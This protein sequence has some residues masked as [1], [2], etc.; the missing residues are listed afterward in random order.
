MTSFQ[1]HTPSTLFTTEHAC[2]TYL[3]QKRWPWGFKCPFCRRVQKDMAPAYTVV[4]R[5]CR[6]Q[7]SITAHTLMHGSKKSLVAWMRVASQF[8]FHEEGISARELQ[9]LMEL[10]CY[11]TAWSWLQKMR[12]GAA[13]A[14]SAPCSGTVL[15]DVL[16]L[17]ISAIPQKKTINIGIAL[18]LAGD[19]PKPARV[20]LSVFDRK[21]SAEL[22][23]TVNTIIQKNTTL[24]IRN[25]Q[26]T[27]LYDFH[28]PYHS[29]VPTPKQLAQGY[30]LLQEA[31]DWLER[32]YRGAID[33]CYLQSYLDEFC[34]R[35]N[36]ASWPDRL[37]VLDHLLTGLI[38]SERDIST[39]A[40]NRGAM[41]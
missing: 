25:Q 6:K 41:I 21:S 37:A 36:T 10:S 5:Y 11:Q 35:H 9:R 18:E 27:D 8:C 31:I 30:L 19:K 32:L 1:T 16:P 26:W 7:T 29:V 24:L 3:F 2:V 14:E 34:F 38:T 17:Q 12:Q 33:T 20:R 40:K 28:E 39:Q 23:A 22:T 4:C 13:L 15:F